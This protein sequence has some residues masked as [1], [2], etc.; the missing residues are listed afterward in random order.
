[1]S[2]LQDKIVLVTGA[3]RGI[4]AATVKCCLE[5]GATVL[6]NCRTAA[7]FQQLRDSFEDGDTARLHWLHYDV[8][9]SDAVKQ[10]FRQI[11]SE[12]GRLDGLVNNAGIMVEQAIAMT[13]KKD[14]NNLF[15]INVSAVYEHIQLAARLMTRNRQ[16]SIVNV[17]SIV[18]QQGAKGQSA[19]AMSKASLAGL[20]LSA[21]KELGAVGIRINTVSPGFVETDLTAHY[22]SDKK[23]ALLAQIPLNRFATA[24][25][26][27]KSIRFLLSEDAGYITGQDIGVNGALTLP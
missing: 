12:F 1:M 23:Q 7:G 2:L 8:V 25:D 16:G 19:Y 22:P 20:T 5:S 15:N 14:M 11:Q 3:S 17:G 9:D 13:A 6:A 4:G 10:Q 24:G 21:A 18:A 26:V 27:A